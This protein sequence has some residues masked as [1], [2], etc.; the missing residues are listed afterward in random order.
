MEPFSIRTTTTLSDWDA[1]RR[2]W[3]SRTTAA[4]SPT[5]AVYLGAAGLLVTLIIIAALRSAH[6]EVQFASMIGG[7]VLGTAA[8]FGR[9]VWQRR[10]VQPDE[11]GS[12]LGPCEFVLDHLGFRVRRPGIEGFVLWS[13][14]RE[15]DATDQ[16]L[17]L[18]LDRISGHLVPLRDL[19]DGISKD[20]AIRRVR[21]FAAQT[22]Q[23]TPTQTGSMSSD[24]IG[25]GTHTTAPSWEHSVA[26]VRG[27]PQRWAT[28]LGRLWTLRSLRGE[29]PEPSDL[30]IGTLALVSLGLWVALDWLR[31]GPGA[32]FLH[33]GLS[34]VAW[35]LLEVLWMAW[36]LS[37]LTHSRL[38]YRTA[39]F[40]LVAVAPV[41]IGVNAV[42]AE[43]VLPLHWIL[44]TGIMLLIYALTYL[45]RGLRSATGRREISGLAAGRAL[46]AALLVA[47]AFAGLRSQLGVRSMLW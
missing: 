30:A 31:I 5:T 32:R 34:G 26:P 19:P 15:V 28:V 23:S 27:A 10:N 9:L 12:I 13:R 1:Y 40:L 41:V 11:D 33:Y 45:A 25:I 42:L 39:L 37:K 6:I 20:E 35:A 22:S 21:S 14:V 36:I 4:R 17:F 46:V 7:V 43:V 2:A 18:W 29:L 16:H 44:L 3:A 38:Q 24:S 8:V 47:V